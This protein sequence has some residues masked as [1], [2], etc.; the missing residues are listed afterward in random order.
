MRK[1]TKD[2]N[3][4]LGDAWIVL[5]LGSQSRNLCDESTLDL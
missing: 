1:L 5:V 4:E 3:D 2:M